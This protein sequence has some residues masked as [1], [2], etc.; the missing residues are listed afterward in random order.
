MADL[1]RIIERAKQELEQ[2][3]D[4][5]PEIMLLVDENGV[6]TRA[7][8]ALL[9]LMGYTTFTDVLNKPMVELF[10]LAE[11]DMLSDALRKRGTREVCESDVTLPSGRKT[12]LRFT[13]VNPRPASGRAVI[14]IHDVTPDREQAAVMEKAHKVEA[15][16]LVAGALMHR[17]NQHLTVITIQ[18]QMLELALEE[19]AAE[20]TTFR[21]ALQEI[22][23]YA[24]K[25][26]ETI[27]RL[28][29]VSDVV[30]E[31]YSPGVDILDLDRSPARPEEAEPLSAALLGV[32]LRIV[33][34]HVP[35]FPLHS[36]RTGHYARFLAQ[37]LGLS[38]QE[39]DLVRQVGELHDIG[40]IAVPSAILC[41]PSSLTTEEMAIMRTHSQVGYNILS[42]FPA[43]QNV[44]DAVH[45][46]HERYDGTG[47]PRGVAGDAIPLAT[48]IVAVADAFEIMRFGRPYQPAVSLQAAVT[49][50]TNNA[51]TQFDPRV[52]EALAGCHSDLDALY[53][54][55]DSAGA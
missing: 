40:K 45:A 15:V 23:E 36:Q 10:A 39:Q 2:M 52:V 29:T 27:A 26:S 20:P 24:A 11:P 46:H 47:Y 53:S 37:R 12:A 21:G 38:E 1:N 43:L 25:I 19:G 50:I 5:N 4:M 8:R 6:V 18:A 3:I 22:V 14:V 48:R 13:C 34:I 41:K 31:P 42:K 9:D 49:D 17:V 51:A 54:P 30:T 35:D 32:L 55:P 28:E 44:A 7:N 33:A 16:R